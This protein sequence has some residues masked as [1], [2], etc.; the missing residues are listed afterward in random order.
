MEVSEVNVYA[1][2]DAG[3][4]PESIEV[5]ASMDGLNYDLVVAEHYDIWKTTG[6]VEKYNIVMPGTVYAKDMKVV[7]CGADND[8]DTTYPEI[9]EIEVYGRPIQASRTRKTSYSYDNEVPFVTASDILDSDKGLTALSDG[10]NN[11]VTTSGDYLSVIYDLGEFCQVDEIKVK[12]NHGGFELLTSPD[13]LTYFSTAYYKS[14]SGESIAYGRTENN[15]KFVKLVFHK[16]AS[17]NIFLSEIELYT[18]KLKNIKNAS[19]NVRATLKPNNLVYL[20]WSDHNAYGTQKTYNVYIEEDYF[21]DVAGLT[22]VPVQVGRGSS[23][24]TDVKANFAT[25][26]GLAPETDYYIAVVEKGGDTAVTPVKITSYDALGTGAAA[27]IFGV[28]EYDG[29]SYIASRSEILKKLNQGD[30]EKI[31]LFE[32]DNITQEELDSLPEEGNADEKVR[33]LLGDIESVQKNRDFNFGEAEIRT[34]ASYGLSWLP[35]SPRTASDLV[36]IGIYEYGMANEPEIGGNYGHS[37]PGT[38]ADHKA[39]QLNFGNTFGPVIKETY[40]TLK[41]VNPDALLE[42]PTLCGTDMWR[43]LDALYETNPDIGD[44]YDVL[45]VH[46]YNKSCDDSSELIEG[47]DWNIPEKVFGK[48]ALLEGI[49]DKYGDSKPIISTETGWSDAESTKAHTSV[50]KEVNPEQKAE[51]VAR[52]YLSYIM[53]GVSECYLYAFQDEGYL[54]DEEIAQGKTYIT[55]RQISGDEYTYNDLMTGRPTN[56]YIARS[57]PCHEHQFGIVDWWGNP[58]EGYYSFYTVG[59][60]LRDA[61]YEGALNMPNLCYGAVFYDKLKDKYLTALWEVSGKG[62]TVEVISDEDTLTKI[63]MYGGVSEVEPGNMMLTTSPF[64]IYS[65]EPLEIDWSIRQVISGNGVG[66]NSSNLVKTYADQGVEV[67]VSNNVATFTEASGLDMT[68]INQGVFGVAASSSDNCI[69]SNWGSRTS[70]ITVDLGKNFTVDGADV[71]A[72]YESDQQKLSKL[73]VE[74]STDGVTYKEVVPE[75]AITEGVNASVISEHTT[76]FIITKTQKEVLSINNF[77]PVKA[78]YVKVTLTGGSYQVI[79]NEVVI[80]GK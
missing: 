73:R 23:T 6:D 43:Y 8:R 61:Y 52:M 60:M 5:Y 7:V 12:G 17:S 4:A 44:Y 3:Y 2:N 11:Q 45:D 38:S 34:Y 39:D 36:D 22:P 53:A 20:D 33:K 68:K 16:P 46:M 13:G 79:P 58:E 59:K 55:R 32:E 47:A 64:Y 72:Y 37:K 67:T 15:A 24:Y 31:K 70:T 74:V 40:E 71:T 21:T 51:F 65:D 66:N 27:A 35:Q 56:Y 76:G 57:N 78:R 25:Y 10:L 18:R 62:R 77:T 80:F 1:Y 75:T 26:I 49:L 54:T 48:V 9:Y 30:Y 42:S 14:A 19:V 69:W 50:A 63:D 29:G 41:D 28:N